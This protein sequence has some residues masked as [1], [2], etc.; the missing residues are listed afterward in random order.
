MAKSTMEVIG[1]DLQKAFDEYEAKKESGRI[2]SYSEELAKQASEYPNRSINLTPDYKRTPE[3]EKVTEQENARYKEGKRQQRMDE[4]KKAVN[5]FKKGGK[6][7]SA[8]KR[9]DGCAV[10]GKTKGR[11]V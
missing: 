9:A 1:P 4:V 11:I 7:S 10:K 8:S 3:M 6:V 2:K 5:P